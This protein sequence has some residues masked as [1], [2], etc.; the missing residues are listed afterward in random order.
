[1]YYFGIIKFVGDK[2]NT[3]K[4]FYTR[5]PNVHYQS[6]HQFYKN[7]PTIYY[8]RG[9]Y[10]EHKQIYKKYLEYLKENGNKIMEEEEGNNKNTYW[11]SVEFKNGIKNIDKFDSVINDIYLKQIY[12]KSNN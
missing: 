8:S 2:G 10:P 9:P 4:V 5:N 3:F 1:M 7:T 6:M 12:G 11:S